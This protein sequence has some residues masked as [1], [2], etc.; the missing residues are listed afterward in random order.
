VRLETNKRPELELG[1]LSKTRKNMAT[2][3]YMRREALAKQSPL[4]IAKEFDYTN[5]PKEKID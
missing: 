5:I 4:L 2:T 3:E 1:P